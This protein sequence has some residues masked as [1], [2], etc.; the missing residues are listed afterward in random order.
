MSTQPYAGPES[1][2]PGEAVKNWVH[3][4]LDPDQLSSGKLS[5]GRRKLGMGTLI[6]FWGLRVYVLMMI[7]LVGFQI[8]NAF[9]SG[10]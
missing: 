1:R 8:W 4:E 10:K 5:Y 2:T 7:L 9:S 3:E 6:L